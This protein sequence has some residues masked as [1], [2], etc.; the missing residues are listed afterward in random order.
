MCYLFSQRIVRENEAKENPIDDKCC[1]ADA[2]DAL[3]Q[4]ASRWSL[5]VKVFLPRHAAAVEKGLIGLLHLP[6]CSVTNWLDPLD[7]LVLR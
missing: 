5:L 6:L 7:L 4:T 1:K 2:K 3:T